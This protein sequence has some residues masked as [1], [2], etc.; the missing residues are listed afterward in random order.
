MICWIF[1][2]FTNTLGIR[3]TCSLVLYTVGKTYMNCT[4]PQVR[5]KQMW[6]ILLW[7]FIRF[8]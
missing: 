2:A 6:V 5:P 3:D 4:A 1:T 8:L 7:D